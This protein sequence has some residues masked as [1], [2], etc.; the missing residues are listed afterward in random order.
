MYLNRSFALTSMGKILDALTFLANPYGA[1]AQAGEKKLPPF[2]AVVSLGNVCGVASQI[3]RKDLRAS[4]GPV[5]WFSTGNDEGFLRLLENR[6][7][8]FMKLENLRV[9]GTYEKNI[10]RGPTLS[11]E[12]MKYNVYSMHDLT[13]KGDLII[14][15]DEYKDLK[16]KTDRRVSRFLDQLET[17]D[18]MLFVRRSGSKDHFI[19]LCGLLERMRKGKDFHLMAVVPK[20]EYGNAR[21][22]ACG[23]I[24]VYYEE[25]TSEESSWALDDRE[26]DRILEGVVLSKR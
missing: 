15:L 1:A 7:A 8:D 12:D 17:L 21:C 3:K 20:R 26:W 4:S 5:D 9:M 18:S 24:S 14:D 11:I 22:M 6:F 2:D 25:K 16:E 13:Y 23:R 10:G 19:R